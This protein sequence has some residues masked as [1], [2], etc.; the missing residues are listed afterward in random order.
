MIGSPDGQGY[1]NA[2]SSPYLATA[3]SGDVLAGLIGGFLS[4]EVDALSSAR[5]GCYIHSQCGINL[6]PG[7]TAGDLVKEIPSVIRKI[8]N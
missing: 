7:L 5:L 3:G 6:G 1:I 8:K 2:E 4:Q